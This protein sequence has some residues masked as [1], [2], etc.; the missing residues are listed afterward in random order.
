MSVSA[1]QNRNW[2]SIPCEK[3][4]LPE[5]TNAPCTLIIIRK[6]KQEGD[7]TDNDFNKEE[8]RVDDQQ[9]DDAGLSFHRGNNTRILSTDPQRNNNDL[10]SLL[11]LY[12]I[13]GM[14]QLPSMGE[15]AKRK[16]DASLFSS[17]L[18]FGK[19]VKPNAVTATKCHTTKKRLNE[20]RTSVGAFRHGRGLKSPHVIVV[21]SFG[22]RSGILDLI[23]VSLRFVF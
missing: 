13:R 1:S 17:P 19:L 16:K 21:T 3:N 2:G 14:R 9:C 20:S 12:E 7:Y 11:T 6:V 8:H 10:T 18:S 22:Q 15:G 23:T 4:R 5:L